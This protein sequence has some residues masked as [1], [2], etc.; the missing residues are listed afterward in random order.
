[1]RV[2]RDGVQPLHSNSSSPSPPSPLPALTPK[3]LGNLHHFASARSCHLSQISAD[4]GKDGGRGRLLRRH[5]C[6]ALGRE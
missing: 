2:C 3:Q 5:R 6:K 1:M 4:E